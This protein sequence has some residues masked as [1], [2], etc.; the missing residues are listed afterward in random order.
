MSFLPLPK[1]NIKRCPMNIWIVI[2]G[3]APT[4]RYY[5]M[6]QG[7]LQDELQYRN[8]KKKSGSTVHTPGHTIFHI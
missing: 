7:H 4:F 3:S 6:R 8:H 2:A 5:H 1:K